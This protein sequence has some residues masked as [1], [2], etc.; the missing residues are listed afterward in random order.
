[1]TRTARYLLE[2]GA[3]ATQLLKETSSYDTVGNAYFSLTMHAV[4]AAWRRIAV[5]TS[6]F[7]MTRTAALFRIM[8]A[9]AGSQLYSDPHRCASE[10]H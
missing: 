4:P 7:H 1:V 2:R 5:V 9:L 10:R 3:D 6:H 8:Y